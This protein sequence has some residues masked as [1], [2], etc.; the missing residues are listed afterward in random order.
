MMMTMTMIL[1]TIMNHDD[2]DIYKLVECI[3]SVCHKSDYFQLSWIV[4]DDDIYVMDEWHLL[5][6]LHLPSLPLSERERSDFN[7]RLRSAIICN[8]SCL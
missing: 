6:H 1:M 2:D 8:R 3:L 5:S 4:D 7:D